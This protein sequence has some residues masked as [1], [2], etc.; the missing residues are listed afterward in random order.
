M[1][2]VKNNPA[3]YSTYAPFLSQWDMDREAGRWP[4][5][6]VNTPVADEE[7]EVGPPPRRVGPTRLPAAPTKSAYFR[8]PETPQ[9]QWA[10]DGIA[11]LADH[12]Q[13]RCRERNGVGFAGPHVQI[14]HSLYEAQQNGWSTKQFALALK[15]CRRYKN[16]Q[17]S[18]EP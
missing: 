13:D 3:E 4:A 12:D 8:K 15:I 16:T 11:H 6:G 5:M 18:K 7:E 10:W 9:E 1:F 17:L 2:D 14:G